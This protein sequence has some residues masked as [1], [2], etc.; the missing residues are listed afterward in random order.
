MTASD[1][2]DKFARLFNHAVTITQI[3]GNL[4][5]VMI[6]EGKGIA[7]LCPDVS[8]S[9]GAKPVRAASITNLKDAQSTEQAAKAEG[10]PSLAP[11]SE[12]TIESFA[13]RLCFKNPLLVF[14]LATS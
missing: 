4:A 14:F 13:H 2:Y 7:G 10:R 9:F 12:E 1:T 11:V 8:F 6:M 3:L 5:D